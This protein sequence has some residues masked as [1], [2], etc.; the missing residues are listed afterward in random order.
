MFER[1]SLVARLYNDGWARGDFDVV[2]ELLDPE[3]VWTTIEGAPDSGTYRGHQGVR[4]YMQDWLDSFDF[5]TGASK[6]EEAIEV[7]D[8]LVC[9]QVG[10]GTGKGSQVTSEIHYACVYAFGD[11][12]RIVEVREYATR[13]EA[14]EAA[15]RPPAPHSSSRA[16]A[17]PRER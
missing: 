8:R 4:R 2:F 11:D 1:L 17:S 16:H 14:L 7:G 3:I 9:V 13:E 15:R 5:D 10:I 6:I 12:D